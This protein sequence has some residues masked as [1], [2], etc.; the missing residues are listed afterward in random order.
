MQEGKPVAYYSKKLN[1]AQMNYATIDK[2]LLC[3]IATLRKFCSMLL[4]AELHVHADHKNILSI[5][6]SSQQR[7]CWISYVDEYG[8]ELNYVEG[9]H[10]VIANTFSRLL[11]SNVSSSL[12]GKKATY[13]Y[14]NSESGNR[15]ESSHSSLM[16]DR[17]ITD[18]LM[19]L[20][21]FLFRKKKEGRPTKC[22]KCSETILD[23]QN[24]PKLLSYTYDATVEQCYLNLPKNMVKDNPF[25][26]ENIKERQDYDE[27][28]MKSTVKY[29]EWYTCK[30]INNVDDILCYVKPGDNP[31]NWK[32]ALP[33]DLIKPTIKWY[34]QV[35]GLC[36]Y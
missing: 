25:D 33:E 9:P 22:R 13:V 12:V 23:E 14:I 21:C 24:K 16:D 17:D 26:L 2:E 32:I 29:P 10:N 28:L 19:T 15:N 6:D 18:C 5:G 36:E 3:V 7:L 27:K 34:H 31:A 1:S 4:G 20:P 11:C 30:T 35:T 8:L